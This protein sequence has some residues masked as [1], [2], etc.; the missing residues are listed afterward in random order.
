MHM[1]N[2]QY[3]QKMAK[4]CYSS[5]GFSYIVLYTQ[6]QASTWSTSTFFHYHCL[7]GR[8]HRPSGE[9]NG[10]ANVVT[11]HCGSKS[12]FIRNNEFEQTIYQLFGYV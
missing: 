8:D 10:T 9:N 11:L 7:T 4:Q 1:S 5:T 6:C 2:G 12:K 3:I